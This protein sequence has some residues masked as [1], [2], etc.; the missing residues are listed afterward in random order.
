[1]YY[2]KFKSEPIT[3]NQLARIFILFRDSE[4]KTIK[5]IYESLGSEHI[6]A[7]V[8]SDKLKQANLTKRQASYFI[9]LLYG[10]D[11]LIK[12]HNKKIIN[13]CKQIKLC[14]L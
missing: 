10:S 13:F 8:F 12:D 2:E 11:S 3:S 4:N 9:N 1:M 5:H 7:S 6:R 14:N